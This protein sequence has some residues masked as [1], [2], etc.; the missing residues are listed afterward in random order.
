[1]KQ[2]RELAA[3]WGPLLKSYLWDDLG[4]LL[5]LC[6]IATGLWGFAELADEVMERETRSVDEEIL[7]LLRNP[8]DLTDPVGA[9]WVEELGRDVTALG[10]V[11]VLTFLTVTVAGYLVLEKKPQMALFLASTVGGGIVVSFLLKMVFERPRPDLV[12]HGSHVYTTSFPSGHSM[13][14]ALTYLTLAV[15]LARAHVRRRVKVFFVLVGGLI[16]IAVGISRVYLGVHWPTDV[17]AGW[18][19]GTV[20]AILCWLLARRLQRKGQIES[21]GLETEAMAPEDQNAT[22]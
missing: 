12:P 5:G 13:M 6:L 16:A 19:A 15:V 2:H 14:A 8:A 3:K 21:A 1:M 9:H 7:L 4:L 22:D 10:G 18:T 11:A 17:L 20:W